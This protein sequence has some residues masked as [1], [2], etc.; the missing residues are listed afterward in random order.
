MLFVLSPSGFIR[1]LTFLKELISVCSLNSSCLSRFFIN[2]SMEVVMMDMLWVE[3]S[4]SGVL[5]NIKSTV[6]NVIPSCLRFI[7]KQNILSILPFEPSPHSL[8]KQ[9]GGISIWTFMKPMVMW[10]L[11]VIS[12]CCNLSRELTLESW[13][14]TVKW[15]SISG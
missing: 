13:N 2:I 3:F 14:Y 1:E 7:S 5:F 9:P 8:G 10:T 6:W 11:P 12:P 4:M 15:K